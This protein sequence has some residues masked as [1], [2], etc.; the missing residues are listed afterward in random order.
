MNL[1]PEGGSIPCPAD[2]IPD[3]TGLDAVTS[4]CRAAEKPR[5]VFIA[6]E[7]QGP[8]WTVEADVLSAPQSDVDAR[9]TTPYER[10]SST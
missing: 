10:P 1:L 3:A 2:L 4:V 8:R 6:V 9:C 5:V 7:R